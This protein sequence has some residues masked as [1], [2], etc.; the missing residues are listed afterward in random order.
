MPI[1]EL[2]YKDYFLT[3]LIGIGR[4]G[5]GG[6]AMKE[7]PGK[8]VTVEG[9]NGKVVQCRLVDIKKGTAIVCGEQE[10]LSSQ[11][12]NRQPICLGF[13]LSSLKEES[14]SN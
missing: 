8:L 13:P 3:M 11:N 9:F 14:T 2:D 12:E 7:T 4:I 6:T 10:W 5:G 1:P